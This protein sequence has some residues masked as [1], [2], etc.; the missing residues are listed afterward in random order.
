MQ[1]LSEPWLDAVRDELRTALAARP[2]GPQLV[3]RGEA[4]VQALVKLVREMGSNPLLAGRLQQGL[5]RLQL[6][7]E[8]GAYGRCGC[9][10][11]RA[12]AASADAPQAAEAAPPLQGVITLARLQRAAA[13]QPP[14]LAADAVLT[15]QARDWVRQ[16]KLDVQRSP[17]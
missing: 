4:D 6:R 1:G 9:P 17:T 10:H 12:P 8:P 14:R 5:G 15:P 7:I 3:I 13:Q 16:C 11:E 2:A